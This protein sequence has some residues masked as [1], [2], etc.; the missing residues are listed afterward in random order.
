MAGHDE[1]GKRVLMKATGGA[2]TIRNR[3][4]MPRRSHR[5]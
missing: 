3:T 5:R 2:V 4:K 1:Y